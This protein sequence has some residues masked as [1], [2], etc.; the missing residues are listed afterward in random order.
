MKGVGFTVGFVLLI[1]G[2]GAVVPRP[3]FAPDD[4]DTR[5]RRVFLLSNPI[6]TDLAVPLDDELLERF[7][8]LGRDGLPLEAPGAAYLVFGW[9]GR[10]FYLETPTWSE[11]KIKPLLKGLT[12]DRAAMHVALAGDI[13]AGADSVEIFLSENRYRALLDYI[14]LSFSEDGA[15]EPIHIPRSGY[16]DFDT[17]Y[18]GKGTF[19]ALLGCNTWTAAGLR[20][21]GIQTGLWNPIPILLRASL[22]IHGLS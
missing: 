1:L 12:A 2:L 10:A 11:L 4:T 3:L 6:H 13:S 22:R 7:A 19:T 16:G 17:F 14:R 9:G 21:A 18:E 20:A 8:F 15:G 5:P